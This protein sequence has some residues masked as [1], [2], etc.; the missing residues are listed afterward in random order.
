MPMRSSS[1]QRSLGDRERGGVTRHLIVL[2]DDL[3]ATW[4][5]GRLATRATGL[6]LLLIPI[7]IQLVDIAGLNRLDLISACWGAVVAG[8]N[9]S[10]AALH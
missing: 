7:R 1:S 5:C 6:A 8:P 10:S 3:V 9:V 2:S 4:R